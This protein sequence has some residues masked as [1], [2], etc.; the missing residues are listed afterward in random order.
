MVYAGELGYRVL[1][2]SAQK[3]VET[4]AREVHAG[5]ALLLAATPRCDGTLGKTR[6]S[7]VR[8]ALQKSVVTRVACRRLT[9]IPAPRPRLPRSLPSLVA[10]TQPAWPTSFHFRLPPADWERRML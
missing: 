5:L 9:S 3:T 7:A 2:A 10:T 4:E 1:L 6:L 8:K